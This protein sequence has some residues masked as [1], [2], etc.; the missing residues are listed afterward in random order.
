MT[1]KVV[2]RASERSL[3]NGGCSVRKE[4]EREIERRKTARADVREHE[5]HVV[6]VNDKL[7][8]NAMESK[9]TKVFQRINSKRRRKQDRD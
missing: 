8:A 9:R 7:N 4:T 3:E 5:D 6:K 2:C 1:S